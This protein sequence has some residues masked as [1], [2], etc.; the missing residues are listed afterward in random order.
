MHNWT[1]KSKI[2]TAVILTIV[3]ITAFVFVF[4][5]FNPSDYAF[6]PKCPFFVATGY[7][8][9]GCGSQRAIHALLNGNICQAFRFNAMMLICIPILVFL[10]LGSILKH[11]YP[12]LYR[13]TIHPFLSWGLMILI[14]SWWLLRN[15]FNW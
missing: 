7:K 2:I 12:Q 1:N 4:H 13:I 15:L 5:R 9:P 11:K 3:S 6:F 14:L 8:C 10:S